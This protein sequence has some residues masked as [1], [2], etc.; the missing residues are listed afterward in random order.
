MPELGPLVVIV[1]WRDAYFDF[2]R[3]GEIEIRED[4]LVRTVGYVISEGPRFISL[5]QELL[6]DGDCR[7]VTNIPVESVVSRE[8]IKPAPTMSLM[9]SVGGT[10]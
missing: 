1:T 8:V 2:D 9:T 6:P 10:Q 3:S 4:Y 5:A 7:A